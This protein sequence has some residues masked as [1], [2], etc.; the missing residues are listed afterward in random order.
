MAVVFSLIFGRFVFVFTAFCVYVAVPLVRFST[1]FPLF[2]AV[3]SI[4]AVL[5]WGGLG[6]FGGV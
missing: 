3:L 6:G 4:V 2:L 5:F 1:F